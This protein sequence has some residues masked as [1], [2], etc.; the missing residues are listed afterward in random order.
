MVLESKQEGKEF[1]GLCTLVLKQVR[2]PKLVK[3]SLRML[4]QWDD[5]RKLLIN[6]T[7]F[8]VCGV[9]DEESERYYRHR[10]HIAVEE[11]VVR[12]RARGVVVKS[13]LLACH[14]QRPTFHRL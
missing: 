9:S 10:S 7:L 8:G 4:I 6:K 1:C 12:V 5:R 11:Y 13:G 2:V 14:Q 3:K